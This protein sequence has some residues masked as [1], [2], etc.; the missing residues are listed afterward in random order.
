MI[1]YHEKL[2]YFKEKKMGKFDGI[3]LCTDLDD[4]L[5]TRDKR[6]TEKNA[7]ALNYFM[8]N[9]GC[10]SFATGRVV[11]GA[12]LIRSMIEPNA[13]MVCFNGAAIYDF[14]SEEF[15]NTMSLDDDARE[16]IDYVDKNFPNAGIEASSAGSVY[17][18]KMNSIVERH[19]RLEKFPDLNCRYEDIPEKVMK[20]IFMMEENEI[21]GF[22]AAIAKTD[23]HGRYSFIQSSPHYYELLPYG[24]SKGR[25]LRELKEIIGAS[26]SIGMGDTE[27]DISMMIDSDIGIAVAN[28]TDAVKSA[29]DYITDNDN[30]NDA[31]CEV[32]EKIEAGIIKAV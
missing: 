30:N 23:F 11:R 2:I 13:P 28:A 6:V 7:A 16:V 12:R 21:D 20:V 17:F 8:E 9:G 4:T 32:I 5:L 14:S 24:A 29:A 31:V 15:L 1:K 10:F 18:C 22:K 3:L 27:N 19:K 26:V 25:G